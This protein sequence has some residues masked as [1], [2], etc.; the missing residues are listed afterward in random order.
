[1]MKYT[2]A[3]KMHCAATALLY[4]DKAGNAGDLLGYIYNVHGCESNSCGYDSNGRY[5]LDK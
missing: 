2:E 5:I 1:M 4:G 3:Y